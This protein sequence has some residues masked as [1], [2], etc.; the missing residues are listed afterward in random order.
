[1]KHER[2]RGMDNKGQVTWVS[3]ML[4]SH[5]IILFHFHNEFFVII[6]GKHEYEIKYK[7]IVKRFP[8]IIK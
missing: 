7:G 3:L 1:M 6:K 8:A 4:L 2:T 5:T